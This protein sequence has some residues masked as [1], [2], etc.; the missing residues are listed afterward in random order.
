MV[1]MTCS[2]ILGYFKVN[3]LSIRD[4]WRINALTFKRS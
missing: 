3:I 4:Y 2:L 1:S